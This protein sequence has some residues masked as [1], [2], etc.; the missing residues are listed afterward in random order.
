MIIIPQL[1]STFLDY[2]SSSNDVTHAQVW[3][4]FWKELHPSMAEGEKA[5]SS[6]QLQVRVSS[7]LHLN[8]LL[9]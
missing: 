3:P 2:V 9:P 5:L 6:V 7:I 4:H 1:F 8:Y